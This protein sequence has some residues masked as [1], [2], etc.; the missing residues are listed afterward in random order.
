MSS[1]QWG[2]KH[3]WYNRVGPSD[4]REPWM[5]PEDSGN[6]YYTGAN[7][8][9]FFENIHVDELDSLGYQESQ[10]VRPV[11]GYASYAWD[12]LQYGSRLVQGYFRVN[13]TK[14]TYLPLI[15]TAIERNRRSHAPTSLGDRLQSGEGA[16]YSPD[17]M[18]AGPETA[19]GQF[20]YTLDEAIERFGGYYTTEQVVDKDEEEISVL[21]GLYA[22]DSNAGGEMPVGDGY[23]GQ[24]WADVER[25]SRYY[26]QQRFG[27]HT[28]ADTSVGGKY[29]QRSD[30]NAVTTPGLFP[31]VPGYNDFDYNPRG[32]SLRDI[33]FTMTVAFGNIDDV[34]RQGYDT[35]GILPD[36]R[37]VLNFGSFSGTVRQLHEVHIIAGPNVQIDLDGKP[38]G[39][40]YTFVA[41]DIT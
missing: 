10:N 36:Q 27:F 34:L 20:G 17:T 5:T 33:G 18:P 9:V 8:N 19:V 31:K 22:I 26:D 14:S 1:T 40:L 24:K 15:L 16:D 28:R 6:N 21:T 37:R 3:T 13:L 29:I 41:K 7:V 39:E 11:Y 35:D 30:V 12:A 4:E 25:L 23:M 38:L 2:D 32:T